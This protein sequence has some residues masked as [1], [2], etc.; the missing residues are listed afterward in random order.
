MARRLLACRMFAWST[1]GGEA[2][3]EP[4][5]LEPTV[6]GPLAGGAVA[7]PCRPPRKAMG[8]SRRARPDHWHSIAL[9]VAGISKFDRT[10]RC[11]RDP[12][13]ADGLAP[14]GSSRPRRQPLVRAAPGSIR[15]SSCRTSRLS[16]PRARGPVLAAGA[17]KCDNHIMRLCPHAAV[18]PLPN[19]R[20]WRTRCL[21][22]SPEGQWR[23]HAARPA[24]RWGP[25][26]GRDWNVT[27]ATPRASITRRPHAASPAR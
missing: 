6:P 18:R 26:R 25:V 23:R 3:A 13:P 14:P 9:F 19:R 10:L 5:P 12:C 16:T 8:A 20:H 4:T 1:R 27:N 22:P 7:A 15:F 17:R 24:R 11:A 21:A 2:I